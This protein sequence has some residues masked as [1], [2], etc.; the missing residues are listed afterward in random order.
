MAKPRDESKVELIFQAA[1]R[2]VLKEGFAGLKMKDVAREAGVATG[3]LYIYFQDKE[4]L[5]NAL[6]VHLKQ[7]KTSQ[8]M[9]SYDPEDPFP[10]TF[11]KLWFS[12]FEVGLREPERMIFIEQFARSPYLTPETRD[13]GDRM[14]R[15][16]EEILAW[17]I[18]LHIVADLPPAVLVSQLMGPIFELVKLHHDGHLTLT[19][20]LMDQC[21]QMAWNSIR[22]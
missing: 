2:V 4:A 14:L 16:F 13:Q 20:A 22:R 1:L 3:T 15:P 21:F 18:R 6:Y 10:V 17:G 19:P 7:A 5:I 11:K 12:F 8:V 9:M